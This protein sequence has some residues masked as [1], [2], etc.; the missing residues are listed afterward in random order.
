MKSSGVPKRYF[1]LITARAGSKRLPGKNLRPLNGV[2]L[3]S[4][5]IRASVQSTTISGTVVSTDS[6]EIRSLALREGCLNLDLRPNCLASDLADSFDVVSF[7]LRRIESLYGPVDFIV[8][9]QPT[10]PLRGAGD[11]E[12]AIQQFEMAGANTLTSITKD[13]F[14]KGER[15]KQNDGKLIVAAEAD[16]R[17]EA[18]FRENGA[19]YILSRECIVAGNFYGDFTV[20]YE[21]PPDLSADI[22]TIEDFEK[23]EV[24]LKSRS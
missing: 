21:M 16:S 1:G 9:L 17:A 23:A 20:G 8:L 19:I 10:S 14:S 24:F 12:R 6:S 22:D 2:P 3:V 11:I 15:W 4:Y 5:T 18:K 7:E 13:D